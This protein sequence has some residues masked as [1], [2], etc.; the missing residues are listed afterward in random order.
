MP[1][2][3]RRVAVSRV[4]AIC[5][6]ALIQFEKNHKRTSRFL[7]PGPWLLVHGGAMPF[8]SGRRFVHLFVCCVSN[9]VGFGGCGKTW[10]VRWLVEAAFAS[11]PQRVQ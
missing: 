8:T 9:M 7:A 4:E 1:R 3:A 2:A 10:G 11:Y 5:S 6:V